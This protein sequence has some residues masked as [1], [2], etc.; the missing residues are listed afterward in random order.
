MYIKTT[1]VWG[2]VTVY[3]TPVLKVFSVPSTI[4]QSLLQLE[5]TISFWTSLL[6]R[7]LFLPAA[8]LNQLMSTLDVAVAAPEDHFTPQKNKSTSSSRALESISFFATPLVQAGDVLTVSPSDPDTFFPLLCSR[9]DILQLSSEKLRTGLVDCQTT[10]ADIFQSLG[11]EAKL[12][13][14][15]LSSDPGL[16]YIPLRST[17]ERIAWVKAS[18]ADALHSVLP[19][20]KKSPHL[21]FIRTFTILSPLH[22]LLRFPKFMY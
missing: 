20:F 6:P 3:L 14:D 9:V 11:I 2:K 8:D 7:L 16:T 1:L 10:I 12:L 21:F 18:L 19:A 15:N 22:W 5:H 17:W 4:L 13:R